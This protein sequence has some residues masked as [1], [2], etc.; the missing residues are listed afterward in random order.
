MYNI[1]KASV[2]PGSVQQTMP[3]V[4]EL[5]VC[6]C[7]EPSLTI[8]RVCSLQL[9]LVLVSVVIFTA[10]K[11]SSI[12]HLYLQFYMT[13]FCSYIVSCQDSRSM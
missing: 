10:V 2:S 7:G 9:L 12:Y 6:S 5:R 4:R 8:G 1:Y 3:Y 11:I 13:I